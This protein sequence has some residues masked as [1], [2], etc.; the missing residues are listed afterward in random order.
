MIFHLTDAGRNLL[1]GAMS[2]G[3]SVYSVWFTRAEFGNGPA[4][5]P[6]AATALTNALITGTFDSVEKDAETGSVKMVTTVSNSALN[7]GF[8]VTEVGYFAGKKVGNA[9]PS[10]VVL[11]AIGFDPDG[12]AFRLPSNAEYVSQFEF[13]F[14]L[15]ISD[16]ENINAILNQN[17][18]YASAEDF[19]SHIHNY[20]NPHNVNAA[21]VGL[22][23]VPNV[24][25]NDQTPT[26]T[27]ETVLKL[28]NGSEENGDTLSE[29]FSKLA[30][31]LHDFK[32]HRDDKNNPHE[33]TADQIGAAKAGHTH[34]TNDLT[35]GVLS[36][37]RGGTGLSTGAKEVAADGYTCRLVIEL[38]GGL[39]VQAGALKK[40]KYAYNVDVAF[41]RPYKNESYLL[42]IT[43]CYGDIDNPGSNRV[44][45]AWYRPKKTKT[46]FTTRSAAN[47]VSEW[48]DWFAI[49]FADNSSQ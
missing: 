43:N 25:T 37:K 11:F 17:A 45:P 47:L 14:D 32:D 13:E 1:L 40:E 41:S 35:D 22:D 12:T 9:A 34:H 39:L 29:L 16:T 24:Y 36:V 15:I 49:G 42:Y 2:N 38:P 6:A 19:D 5:D 4:Q 3:E 10:D 46:G 30:K 28:L 27:E 23:R 7:V 33:V 26:F 31:G 48:A 20:G 44:D 18:N 21:Q 8:N